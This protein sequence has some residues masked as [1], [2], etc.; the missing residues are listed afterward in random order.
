M[1]KTYM[2]VLSDPITAAEDE[3]FNTWYD[4]A[5]IPEILQLDGVLSASRLRAS[6]VQA[7]GSVPSHRYLAMY[8]LDG[9]DARGV[10]DR[11]AAARPSM[12]GTDTLDLSSF[13]LMVFD[14]IRTWPAVSTLEE[15]DGTD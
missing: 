6:E 7:P 3:A 11:M 14:E 10:L 8:E 5:H 9:S 12:T 2:V 15:G 1:Q 13:Q 4:S